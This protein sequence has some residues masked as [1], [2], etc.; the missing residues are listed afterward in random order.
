[1]VALEYFQVCDVEGH[2]F[3]QLVLEWDIQH[4][5]PRIPLKA[6]YHKLQILDSRQSIALLILFFFFFAYMVAFFY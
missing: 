6:P 1:M 5:L 3:S 2:I 4:P